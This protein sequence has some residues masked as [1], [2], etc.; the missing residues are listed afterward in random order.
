MNAYTNVTGGLNFTPHYDGNG[1]LLNDETHT[2]DYNFNSKLVGIDNTGI[3]YKY[4]ALGRRIARDN[5][6]FYYMGDQVVESVTDGLTTS[7][8]FGNSIDDA[9]QVRKLNNTH[10]YHTN[11]LGSTMAMTDDTGSTVERVDYDAYGTPTFVAA[12]G[13]ILPQS[14]IGNDILFTGREY[15]AA[16]GIYHYR[17]RS[18]PPIIGRFMQKDPLMYV[19]GMND[20]QYANNASTI[21]IDPSG[22]I[23]ITTTI[24]IGSLV[25][26]NIAAWSTYY[27]D[28]KFSVANTSSK[29]AMYAAVKGGLTTGATMVNPLYGG[30]L[31]ANFAGWET[32]Y[33][34]ECNTFSVNNTSSGKVA[35][36]AGIAGVS[37]FLGGKIDQSSKL[38]GMQ[39]FV[40][41]VLNDAYSDAITNV[42]NLAFEGGTINANVIA[43]ELWGATQSSLLGN[44]LQSL[45]EGVGEVLSGS[46]PNLSRYT[47][48]Q[49]QLPIVTTFKGNYGMTMQRNRFLTQR[50][51]F[52]QN[53]RAFSR[54]Y[55][56]R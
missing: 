26:A 23:V 34:E 46:V 22:E 9:L 31:A 25:A 13:S 42:G 16:A 21:A 38:T 15:D 40:G 48:P 39:Q 45:G 50:R 52:R 53:P 19:D 35:F 14:S 28:G 56:R 36:N 3:T 11:H 20:M 29:K 43:S 6:S 1:N 2:Y 7:Y 5:T 51:H 49:L 12:D 47:H 4:D 10:Y 18:L 8:L 55:Y 24:V 30:L 41:N 37:Q 44:S 33:D 17:A 54:R 32:Y 27:K